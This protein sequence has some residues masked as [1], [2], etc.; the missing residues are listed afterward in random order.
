MPL[1]KLRALGQFGVLTDPKPFDLPPQAFSMGTNV[2]FYDGS[3]SRGPVFRKAG[4]LAKANPRGL[5]AYETGGTT[6]LYVAYNDGTIAQWSTAGE[7]DASIASYTPAVAS[8]VF[9][10]ATL[11]GVLYFN[12]NDRVPWALL[13]S[14]SQFATLAHWDSTWRCNVLRAFNGSLVALNVTKGGTAFPNMVKTSDFA[15]SGAVPA[16]WDET[17]P[18]NNAYENVLAEMKGG[19]VDGLQLGSSAFYIYSNKETWEMLPTRDTE[20]YTVTRKFNDAGALSA[21]CV[22]EVDGKHF[23]FG[24]NDIWMHDGTGKQSIATNKVRKFIF[25]SIAGSKATQSFIA[26]NA[27]LK[28]LHFCFNSGDAYTAFNGSGEDG[29]N[30]SAVYNYGDGTWTFDDQPRVFAADVAPLGD[31]L[32]WSNV[33]A[34]WATIGGSWQ[35]LEDTFTS[36]PI[37]VSGLATGLTA[38]VYVNDLYG[39]GSLFTFPVDPAANPPALLERGGI[40]LDELNDDL[41]GYKTVR[42]VYPQATLDPSGAT[43]DFQ[44]GS[45]DAF[46]EAPVFG[47]WQSY[48]GVTDTKCDFMSAG[49]YLFFKARYNDYKTFALSGM[50]FDT[51]QTGKR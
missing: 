47:D 13:P 3:V 7:T 37:Y 36:G 31:T 1:S 16:S 5:A 32:T 23:V 21:N 27:N 12:R 19:I 26:H 41:T 39:E 43:L 29:C 45:A 30:R 50:D 48:D 44:F 51:V 4:S 40:D 15:L 8:S 28:E 2:R 33:T 10:N 24:A 6:K 22:I 20:V 49:R 35:S 46:N 34:T 38:S 14:A 11:S 9:T 17:D 25:K 18:T 42:A